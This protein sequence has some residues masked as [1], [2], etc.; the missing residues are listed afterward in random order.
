M[1]VSGWVLTCFVGFVFGFVCSFGVFLFVV[2]WFGLFFSSW[3]QHAFNN[4]VICFI[5]LLFPPVIYVGR[6]SIMEINLATNLLQKVGRTGEE[7]E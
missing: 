2:F 3:N 4:K 7:K 5:L 1:F 6:Q